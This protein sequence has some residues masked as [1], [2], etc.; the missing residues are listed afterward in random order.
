M[1]WFTLVA[2]CFINREQPNSE[3]HFAKKTKYRFTD[4]TPSAV[5][6]HAQKIQLMNA[7]LFTDKTFPTT[8]D[9]GYRTIPD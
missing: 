7:R 1:L 4:R 9:L 6:I 2:F 8:G 3:P 5:I